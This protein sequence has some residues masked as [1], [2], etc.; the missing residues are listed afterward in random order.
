MPAIPALQTRGSGIQSNSQLYS[1][2][3]ASLNYMV[4]KPNKS[5]GL[6]SQA[7]MELRKGEQKLR[8]DPLAY[9]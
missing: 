9:Y 7:C 4:S 6:P 3:M 8:C 5:C 1:E 2:F